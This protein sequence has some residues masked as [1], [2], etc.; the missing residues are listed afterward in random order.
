MTIQ[1]KI[2]SLPET[3][4]TDCHFRTLQV[5]MEVQ[6]LFDAINHIRDYKHMSLK[7][8]LFWQVTTELPL[9]V[10]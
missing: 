7:I 10:S 3:A 2:S 6:E 1:V 4:F 9:H 5:V 8:C